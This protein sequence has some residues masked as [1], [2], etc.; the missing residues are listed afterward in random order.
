MIEAA[1]K[2][3]ILYTD[4]QEFEF[5]DSMDNL[6]QKLPKYFFR[7]HKSY[8]VNMDKVKAVDYKNMEITL[9]DELVADLS[10]SNKSEF[11]GY[12]TTYKEAT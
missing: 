12:M 4:S 11:M 1:N 9:E 2:K 7:V 6:V 3:I 5:Y 8:I 10:R